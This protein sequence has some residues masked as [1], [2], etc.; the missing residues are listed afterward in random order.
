[1][2][3]KHKEQRV[4]IFV[5]V[6]NLYYW[7]KNLYQAK[8]NFGALL[9]HCVA[10]RKLIRAAAYV[11]RGPQSID[12]NFF[13]ALE[14]QGFEIKSKDLQVFA[15]GTKK[16]DWDVG[17]AI[18]AIKLMNHLEV[19]VLVSGDGDY[20]PAVEYLQYNGTLVEVAAFGETASGKLKEIADDFIDIS[21]HAR[22]FLIH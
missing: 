13:K 18:D 4:G 1:M 19:V 5:D 9:T 12:D 6:Q 21:R 20:I 10:G 15:G 7:A 22:K 2:L 11:I 3:I 17:L 8:V 16:G 14:H